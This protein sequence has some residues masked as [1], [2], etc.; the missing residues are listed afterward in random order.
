MGRTIGHWYAFHVSLSDIKRILPE[1]A[2]EDT[3]CHVTIRFL[4]NSKISLVTE[5]DWALAILSF[6]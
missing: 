2:G 6:Q 5:E 4:D 1:L 3:E